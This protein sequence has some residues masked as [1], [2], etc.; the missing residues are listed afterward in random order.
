MHQQLS[1]EQGTISWHFR[2]AFKILSKLFF[3]VIE[4]INFLDDGIFHFFLKKI[5]YLLTN[6]Q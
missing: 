4:Q 5:N 6:N 3:F 1:P 2:L